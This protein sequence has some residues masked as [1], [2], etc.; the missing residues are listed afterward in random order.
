M[1]ACA[2]ITLKTKN[3]FY[4]LIQMKNVKKELDQRAIREPLHQLDKIR[5]NLNFQK[6]YIV[7]FSYFVIAIL[8]KPGL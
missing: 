5:N 8:S 1:D 3:N 7:F 4:N 6:L 2:Y